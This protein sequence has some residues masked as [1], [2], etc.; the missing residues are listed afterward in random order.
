MSQP[1]KLP[2]NM[3]EWFFTPPPGMRACIISW[4]FSTSGEALKVA[5]QAFPVMIRGETVRVLSDKRVTQL[6]AVLLDGKLQ[7][8]VWFSQ[9]TEAVRP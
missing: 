3:I 7:S 2:D 1:Y 9:V 5:G 8:R 4:G 6:H